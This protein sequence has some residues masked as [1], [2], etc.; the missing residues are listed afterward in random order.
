MLATMRAS[1]VTSKAPTTPRI[2]TEAI[3]GSNQKSTTARATNRATNVSLRK[4]WFR[5]HTGPSVV[6]KERYSQRMARPPKGDDATQDLKPDDKTQAGKSGYEDRPAATQQDHGR[7]Q[8][9][10][11]QQEAL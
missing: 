11:S 4:R 1:A 2:T 6:L 10:R 8:E 5:T 7:L 9:D 3:T